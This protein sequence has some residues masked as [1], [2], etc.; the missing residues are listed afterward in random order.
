VIELGKSWKKTEEEG[1]P[2]REPTVSINLELWNLSDTGPPTRQHLTAD[3][4]PQH[5]YSRWLMSLGS[6]TEA[7]PNPQKTIGSR[8]VRS[9]V[10]WD[11]AGDILVETGRQWGGMKWRT[12][13]EFTRRGYVVLCLCCYL[14][15]LAD[16]GIYISGRI[17][18]WDSGK[19]DH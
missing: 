15:L 11:S 6:V 1:N 4:S 8:E 3:K 14:W 13:R 12:V 9:L 2:V 17:H 10:G 16:F 7:A 5:I 18:F 19:C